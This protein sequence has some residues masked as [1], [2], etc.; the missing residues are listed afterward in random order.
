MNYKKIIIFSILFICLNVEV[1]NSTSI[2]KPSRAPSSM[3]TMQ[4]SRYPTKYPTC[5]PSHYPTNTPTNEQSILPTTYPS[6]DSSS[7]QSTISSIFTTMLPSFK[8]TKIPTS[9]SP[10][11]RTT[12]SIYPSIIPSFIPTS[13]PSLNPSASPTMCPSSVPSITPSMIPT[14]G[15]SHS[16]SINP[17]VTPSFIPFPFPS[18]DPSPN[19]SMTPTLFPTSYPS[20]IPSPSPTSISTILPSSP[21][22]SRPSYTPTVFRTV[23]SSIN[24]TSTPTAL[25]SSDP[26]C[27]SSSSYPTVDSTFT[28]IRKPSKLS[29]SKPSCKKT[30]MPS[31]ILSFKPTNDP[32]NEPTIDPTSLFSIIPSA[33]SSVQHSIDP[34]VDPSIVYTSHP[35]IQSSEKPSAKNTLKPTVQKSIVPSVK[36]IKWPTILPSMFLSIVPTSDPSIFPTILTSIF[37][38]SLPTTVQSVVLSFVPRTL[39]TSILSSSPSINPLVTLSMLHS[40]RSSSY[41]TIFPTSLPITVLSAAPTFFPS[42]LSTS[43]PSS[44]SNFIFP[45]SIRTTNKPSLFAS[46]SLLPS[47]TPSLKRTKEPTVLSTT[48]DPTVDPTTTSTTLFPSIAITII[49]SSIPTSESTAS[50]TVTQSINDP[51]HLY[52]THVMINTQQSLV[53][54]GSI[55]MS[56]NYNSTIYWSVDDSSIHL[57]SLTMSSIASSSS[58]YYPVNLVFPPKSLPSGITLKFTLTSIYNNNHHTISS[59]ILII[60]NNNPRSGSLFVT[61]SHG[62]SFIDYFTFQAIDW[63]DNDLPLTY[64]F[65]YSTGGIEE[66]NNDNNQNNNNNNNNNIELIIQSRSELMKATSMLPPGLNNNYSIQ[67][68]VKVFDNYDAYSSSTFQQVHVFL[69]IGYHKIDR[70]IE[71]YSRL[72]MKTKVSSTTLI[73]LLAISSSTLN[74]IDCNYSPNC[75]DFHRYSCHNTKN[76]CSSCKSMNSIGI[77]GDSNTMCYNN[78]VQYDDVT[79]QD[80]MIDSMT[81]RSNN[82]VCGNDFDCYDWENCDLISHQCIIIQKECQQDCSSNGICIYFDKFSSKIITSCLYNNK[83]CYSKCKCYDGWDGD[84]CDISVKDLESRRYLRDSLLQLFN[85]IYDN[86]SNYN[87][88]DHDD[89]DDGNNY[90][91]NNEISVEELIKILYTLSLKT[92]EMFIDTYYNVSTIITS[93]LNIYYNINYNFNIDDIHIFD[94]LLSI[95]NDHITARIDNTILQDFNDEF[96]HLFYK[97]I[98]ENLNIISQLILKNMV[99]LQ[100]N[101]EIIK[102][103]VRS[104]YI[105]QISNHSYFITTSCPITKWEKYIYISHHHHTYLL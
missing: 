26:S 36:Q 61:P 73:Q 78:N 42:V 81:N 88:N 82:I 65:Y 85:D 3:T 38:S 68:K 89:Y 25:P 55:L 45:S 53:L 1:I 22:S 28:A 105:D 48:F 75:N 94:L 27:I 77:D 59:S 93:I 76:T 62:Y 70:L 97:S 46:S 7:I 66:N 60:I 2:E 86:N 52:N 84:N 69:P 39:V 40:L 30:N 96:N 6:L 91:Y 79:V 101:Y 50:P 90:S 35:I 99:V 58:S 17:S 64:S 98:R 95:I 29:T 10:Y 9:K 43:I 4:L 57:N 102:T 92:D 19:P 8:P 32:T 67:C 87:N 56:H 21:P 103:N 74:H 11:C 63:I 104:I 72:I 71:D 54:Y 5:E 18:Y 41:P 80:D 37:P 23:D 44:S 20:R 14:T 16:S 51:K 47:V 100:Y 15:P 83:N 24:P 49:P 12:T 33:D 34:T 31:I 13:L